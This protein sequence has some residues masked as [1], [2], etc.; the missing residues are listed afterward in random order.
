MRTIDRQL[1][2]AICKKNLFKLVFISVNNPILEENDKK[3][4]F[5]GRFFLSS[6]K[7]RVNFT[8][9]FLSAE[10]II[11][12]LSMSCTVSFFYKKKHVFLLF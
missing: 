5:S 2:L 9:L 10:K 3:R 8:G 11:D 12:V 1:E 7:V 6:G 4:L